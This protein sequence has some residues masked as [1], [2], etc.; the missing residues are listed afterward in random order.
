MTAPGLEPSADERIREFWEAAR[1]HVIR[2]AVP[3][4]FGPSALESVLPPAWSFGAT[5]EHADDLLELVLKGTKTATAGALWDYESE[6]E[7]L[8]EIGTMSILLDGAGE[9][10]A[11]IQNTDVDVVPFDEVTAEHAR[12][13]GEGDRSL[14][15][16]REVH[17]QFFTDHASHEQGFSS[18]MPVVCE[19]FKVLYAV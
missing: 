13:E 17:E 10:R 6:D 11:V 4:Y 5:P 12:L 9:P 3:A 15:H 19:R 7:D 8:P 1:P 14:E 18:A 2:G 16:W